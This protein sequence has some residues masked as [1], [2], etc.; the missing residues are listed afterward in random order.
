MKIA[1]VCGLG[2]SLIRFRGELIGE[3]CDLGHEVVACAPSLEPAL[4]EELNQIGAEFVRYPLDRASTNPFRDRKSYLALNDLFQVHKP[5][6]VFNYTA[7]PMVYGSLAASA[8]GVSRIVSLVTGLGYAFTNSGW[9]QRIL[10]RIQSLLYRT[11]FRKNELVIFQNPDDRSLFIQLGLT[12][13]EKTRQVAGSGIN[14]DRFP[15]EPLPSTNPFCFLMVG[16]LLR[17]KGVHEYLAAAQKVEEQFPGRCRFLLVGGEDPN[18][19][20][21]KLKDLRSSNGQVELLGHR[22]D[23][24]ELIRQCHCFV[25]PSY[26]EG[27]PRSSLEALASGRPV[28]TTDAVGCRETVTPGVN[29]WF[30]KVGDSEGLASAMIEAVK[31]PFDDLQAFGSSSRKL[32]EEVFD[33]SKVNRNMVDFIVGLSPDEIDS[34]SDSC[35]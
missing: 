13:S 23:V 35:A 20:G 32:A 14:L 16:R 15:V 11:A 18:P 3:L 2:S 25:L 27:T 1:I 8:N 30:V 7:K 29:G 22:K 34:R 12:E 33:V 5:D 31:M 6:V 26:R 19:G 21:I 28:I 4:I 10:R 9:K 17:E 24:D